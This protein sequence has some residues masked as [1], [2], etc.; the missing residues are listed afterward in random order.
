MEYV[1][2]W[3]RKTNGQVLRVIEFDDLREALTDAMAY[4]PGDFQIEITVTDRHGNE[5]YRD[6]I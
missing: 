4:M 5:H 2:T 3:T 6:A 1:V